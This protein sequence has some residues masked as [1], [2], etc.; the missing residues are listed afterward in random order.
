MRS[1]DHLCPRREEN[2]ISHQTFPGP[3]SWDARDGYRC[4]SYCGSMH[5]DDVF[6]AI[7]DRLELIPTDKSYKLYVRQ[8]HPKA[9]KTIQVGSES[10]PA[11]NMVTGEPNRDDLTIWER[12]TGRYD[13]KIMGT[14][15][16]TLQAKFYF[17]H[18]DQQQQERFINLLNVKAVNW[19][20]PG[21]LYVLPFF[22]KR[23][24]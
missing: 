2:P 12:I 4:C 7:A 5:P 17:Q 1:T 14:A 3:D 6:M 8:P 15:P 9:G 21:Y 23:G 16:A 20:H 24:K 13:R 22:A 19:G 10:G 11:R 18:F